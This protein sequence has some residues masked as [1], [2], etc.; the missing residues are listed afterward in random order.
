MN[1]RTIR[2]TLHIW[3]VAQLG[4]MTTNLNKNCSWDFSGVYN[5][6]NL[7]FLLSACNLL[8]LETIYTSIFIWC[9]FT[10]MSQTTQNFQPGMCP[11]VQN[12]MFSPKDLHGAAMKNLRAKPTALCDVLWNWW[13]PNDFWTTNYEEFYKHCDRSSSTLQASYRKGISML[14]S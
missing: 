3:N 14:C 1:C 11:I 13:E 6:F 2:H 12:T 8:L 9:N 4:K 7:H 10:C 5:G